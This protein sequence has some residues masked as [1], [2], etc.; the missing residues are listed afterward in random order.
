MLPIDSQ[1]AALHAAPLSHGSGFQGLANLARGAANVI[2]Y[3]RHFEPVTVFETI[4]R[5]HV[6]NMFLTPTMLNDR[7]VTWQKS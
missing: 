2:F 3:P 1:D 7:A 6:T 5:Y 4:E